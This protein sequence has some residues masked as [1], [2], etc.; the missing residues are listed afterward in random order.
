MSNRHCGVR[1]QGL[2]VVKNGRTGSMSRSA[3][4][5]S[6]ASESRNVLERARDAFDS[7]NKASKRAEDRR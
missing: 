5:K 3:A 4:K 6:G 2:S 7:G 1:L